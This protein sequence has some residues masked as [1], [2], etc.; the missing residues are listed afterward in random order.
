MSKQP[1]AEGLLSSDVCSPPH[2]VTHPEK[3]R[4]LI[5]EFRVS[6][7]NISKP[8]LIGYSF[9]DKIQ[10]ITGSHRFAASQ[11]TG[12]LIPVKIY[13]YSYIESIWGTDEWVNLI[14]ENTYD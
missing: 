7:W 5:D 2:R 8:K 11:V 3:L 6:G 14:Q 12:T 10:L 9:Y 13:S 4:Q 1:I